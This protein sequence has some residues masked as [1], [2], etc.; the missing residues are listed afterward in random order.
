MRLELDAPVRCAGGDT[1]GLLGDVV[2]DPA[3]ARVAS[4]VVRTRHASE[5]ARLVPLGLATIERKGRELK[6]A[7][8]RSELATMPT[9]Q[10]FALR[11]IDEDV[12]P[13]AEWD[14]GI[15]DEIP[16]TA[17]GSS[18][19]GEFVGQVQATGAITYD[20]IPKGTIELRRSS[21]VEY[22]DGS[23]A[24]GLHALDL[25]GDRITHVVYEHGFLWRR[26]RVA[27]PVAAVQ[28][29]ATD[30]IVLEPGAPYV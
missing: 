30:T 9:P 13:G 15:E 3:A 11:T 22:P 12:D 5:P 17:Y 20:R 27:V 16:Y 21:V 7:C 10:D 14:V 24:G 1:V 28:R 18:S 29:F 8:T 4:L 26:K 2:V 23:A 19:F 6:L 25:D